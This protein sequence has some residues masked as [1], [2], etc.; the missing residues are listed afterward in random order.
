MTDSPKLVPLVHDKEKTYYVDV[1][2]SII[3]AEEELKKP[4]VSAIELR[5]VGQEIS[6]V[7][8]IAIR[9]EELV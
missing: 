5:A 1:K 2:E 4:D 6:K 3:K 9:L 7:S 8:M